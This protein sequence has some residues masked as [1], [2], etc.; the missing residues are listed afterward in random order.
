LH[1]QHAVPRD[2]GIAGRPH[3]PTHGTRSMGLSEQASDLPIGGD[4]AGR[5]PPHDLVHALEEG[6]SDHDSPDRC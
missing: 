4:S 6:V 2:V 5:Y 3:S 1:V